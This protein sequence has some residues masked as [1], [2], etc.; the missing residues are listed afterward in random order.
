MMSNHYSL[1]SV[2]GHTTIGVIQLKRK[3]LKH[4][5]STTHERIVHKDLTTPDGEFLCWELDNSNFDLDNSQWKMC[6]LELDDMD[7]S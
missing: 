6:V 2:C 5:G 3:K 1:Y 7:W 4:K